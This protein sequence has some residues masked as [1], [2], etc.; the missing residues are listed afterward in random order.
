MA[1]ILLLDDTGAFPLS[2]SGRPLLVSQVA[3]NAVGNAVDVSGDT[4][5]VRVPRAVVAH[6]AESGVGEARDFADHRVI[7]RAVSLLANRDR[8][9]FDPRDGSPV[10]FDEAGISSRGA[11]GAPIFPR[12]DPAVIGVVIDE[13]TDSI[14]LGENR[15]HPGYY[16]CI[17]GYVDHGENLEEAF[18][19][20]VLEETGYACENITYFASQPWA[21]SGSLMM[22]FYATK[23]QAPPAAETDGELRDVLWA[24]RDDLGSLQLPRPGSLART[25]IDGWLHRTHVVRKDAR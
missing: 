13:E 21:P 24:T 25:V 12:L 6:V 22:G 19:R 7:S 16:S 23:V 17:A 20:E 9:L 11:E 8:N 1:R 5:A 10:T 14:L 3:G 18:A 15:R 4:Y 2:R